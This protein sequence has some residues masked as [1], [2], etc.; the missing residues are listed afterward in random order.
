VCNATQTEIVAP[1]RITDRACAPKA[2]SSDSNSE[3]GLG[4]DG[5][6]YIVVA[7][8]AF[9]I[10]VALALIYQRRCRSGAGTIAP[11]KDG[12]AYDYEMGSPYDDGHAQ[13]NGYDS[14]SGAG[15]GGNAYLYVSAT[16]EPDEIESTYM[17]A[18]P[19]PFNGSSR[20]ESPYGAPGG[21][22]RSSKSVTFAEAEQQVCV[23]CFTTFLFLAPSFILVSPTINTQNCI[24]DPAL[25]AQDW[26]YNPAIRNVCEHRRRGPGRRNR[27]TA[28]HSGHG[29]HG[30]AAAA[31]QPAQ[32]PRRVHCVYG[33]DRVGPRRRTS[34]PT[35]TPGRVGRG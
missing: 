7:L 15:V 25:G 11:M 4:E 30:G 31:V 2:V 13:Y 22:S 17:G 29:Q 21:G 18:V 12:R 8:L 35:P 23:E 32:R 3:A 10:F 27:R 19:T 24:P 20:T 6:I 14:P 5:W 9:V 1:T 26:Q 33:V 34:A 28:V 16:D